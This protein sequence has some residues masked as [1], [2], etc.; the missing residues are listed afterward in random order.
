[1]LV[2]LP[3]G[4]ATRKV[5][6]H[7]DR[8]GHLYVIDRASGEVLSADA[9]AHVTSTLG[10]DV[11][12]GALR[13]NPD[14]APRSGRIIRDICPA[15]PGAKS[16]QPSAWSPRTKLLYIPHQNL[17]QD[18]LVYEASYIAATPSLGADVKLTP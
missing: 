1:V 7:A 12:G 17:C 11:A 4:G 10:V 18:E 13:Y 9:F 2:D 16:W 6:L 15:S 14:K 8:N 3:I 5:L